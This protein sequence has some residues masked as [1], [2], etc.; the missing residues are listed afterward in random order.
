MLPSRGVLITS[1]DNSIPVSQLVMVGTCHE[2]DV[3]QSMAHP[4]ELEVFALHTLSVLNEPGRQL[5]EKLT[6]S[7]DRAARHDLVSRS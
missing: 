2:H 3:H 1:C 6:S 7:T 4:G 5:V